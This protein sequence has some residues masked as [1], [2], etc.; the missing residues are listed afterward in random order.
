M[1]EKAIK[2]IV[3]IIIIMA[4]IEGEGSRI[5]DFIAI[6]VLIAQ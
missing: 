5:I 2:I 6:T 3:I 1:M 4:A